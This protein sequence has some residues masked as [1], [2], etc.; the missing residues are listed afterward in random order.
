MD[1]ATAIG[2]DNPGPAGYQEV[3]R[4]VIK[5]KAEA[6]KFDQCKTGRLD[7]IKRTE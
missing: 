3:S 2:R 6:I 5:K 1:E 4:D 7:P